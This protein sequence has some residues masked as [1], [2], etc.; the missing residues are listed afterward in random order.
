MTADGDPGHLISAHRYRTVAE[1]VKFCLVGLS[2]VLLDTAVLVGVVELAGIDPRAAATLAFLAA[3][4]WNY[5]LN[6]MW[7]FRLAP[8]RAIARSYASFVAVCLAGLGV[9]LGVMHLLIEYAGMG[10]RPWYVGAS[11]IGI[12]AGTLA[13]F[14]GSKYVA[15]AESARPTR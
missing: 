12:V 14:L 11:I 7:T 13:N 5:A 2:G 6:R 10:V 1:F 3:V 9:R 4:T 15:F 8:E